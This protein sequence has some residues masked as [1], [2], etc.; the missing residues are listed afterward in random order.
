MWG[1]IEA[2]CSRTDLGELLYCGSASIAVLEGVDAERWENLTNCTDD[3]S[4]TC[5]LGVFDGNVV[6]GEISIANCRV[7]RFGDYLT[8][9]L[10][11]DN[12]TGENW[13]QA[14]ELVGASHYAIYAKRDCDL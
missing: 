2:D 1:G 6:E 13:I 7:V 3:Q 14:D 10:E 8:T 5:L 4:Y 9:T 12:E 11:T